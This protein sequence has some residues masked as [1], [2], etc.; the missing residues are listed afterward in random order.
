M[1]GLEEGHALVEDVVL[2][3]LDEGR[4]DTESL[5]LAASGVECD[6]ADTIIEEFAGEFFSRESRIGD[7]EVESVGN[8]FIL[9][10]VIDDGETVA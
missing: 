8:R 3:V 1:V 6:G 9:V 10:F 7:G 5:H 2:V 4:A